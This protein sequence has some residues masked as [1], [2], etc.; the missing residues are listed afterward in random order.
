MEHPLLLLW[1][2]AELLEPSESDGRNEWGEKDWGEPGVR[3]GGCC[4]DSLWGCLE[5]GTGGAWSPEF[6]GAWSQERMG[7]KGLG[8]A[9]SQE[10][11]M[12]Y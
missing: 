6:G 11:G 9:W 4:T 7:G 8:A 5:A 2:L 1:P 3:N 12:P 10:W